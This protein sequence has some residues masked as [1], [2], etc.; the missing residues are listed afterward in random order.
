LNDIKHYKAAKTYL[1]S[2]GMCYI[3]D[4]LALRVVTEKK[5]ILLKKLGAKPVFVFFAQRVTLPMLSPARVLRNNL[6][7]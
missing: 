3:K 6:E 1:F 5:T 7:D 2:T 4:N